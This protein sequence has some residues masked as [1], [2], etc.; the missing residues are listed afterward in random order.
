MCTR[1]CEQQIKARRAFNW[2]P[3]GDLGIDL[4][5][6]EGFWRKQLAALCKCH[7]KQMSGGCYGADEAVKT[8]L[9][10]SVQ[11]F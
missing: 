3:I 9:L 2:V 1:A 5:S 7:R 4:C 10:D 11:L 8:S 6:A